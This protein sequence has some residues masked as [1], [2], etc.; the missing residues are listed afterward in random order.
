[1]KVSYTWSRW[2]RETNAQPRIRYFYNKVR[3]NCRLQI[4]KREKDNYEKR[5]K[6][7]SEEEKR[8]ENNTRRPKIHRLPCCQ[9]PLYLTCDAKKFPRRQHDL[10]V[11]ATVLAQDYR[12]TRP[13][14]LAS[15]DPNYLSRRSSPHTCFFFPFFA[16][17]LR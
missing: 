11:S 13:T 16:E 10:T 14:R 2:S 3:N 7:E 5:Q 4:P 12:I 6:E 8:E 15:D 17:L 9:L 1:M